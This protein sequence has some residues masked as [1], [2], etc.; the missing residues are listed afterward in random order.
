M[1]ACVEFYFGNLYALQPI[2]HPKC[3]DRTVSAM[4][5][6]IEAYCMMAALCSYV[7]LQ[8]KSILP[9]T[10][11]SIVDLDQPGS[12]GFARVLLDEGKTVMN[13]RED[14]L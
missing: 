8:S 12:A 14:A 11:R 1:V 5:Q 2:L 7:L 13:E 4:D 6:S 10:L 9:P 3:I